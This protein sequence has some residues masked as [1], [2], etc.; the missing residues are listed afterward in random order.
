MLF[1][2]WF[3]FSFVLFKEFSQLATHN[4]VLRKKQQHC[5]T[6]Q[7]TLSQ[8]AVGRRERCKP[9]S[10]I[11]LGLQLWL[12][13]ARTAVE[14]EL[15][16]CTKGECLPAPTLVSGFLW[17]RTPTVLWQTESRR[18]ESALEA[19]C[20]YCRRAQL[21]AACLGSWWAKDQLKHWPEKPLG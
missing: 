9:T 1:L 19:W 4:H 18:K 14:A 17:Q 12:L 21:A 20:Q 8:Y 15:L 7:G 16:A 6:D 13:W 3:G 5:I 10:C 11:Y 2:V